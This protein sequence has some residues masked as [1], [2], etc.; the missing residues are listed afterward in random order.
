MTIKDIII[1]STFLT[2]ILYVSKA[3][4][5]TSREQPARHLEI[6]CE[7]FEA[8]SEVDWQGHHREEAGEVCKFDVD[9]VSPQ[10]LWIMS[11]FSCGSSSRRIVMC[12][13]AFDLF[14]FV[15]LK[16]KIFKKIAWI[17]SNHLHLQLFKLM[18]GKF[19]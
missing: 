12:E 17:Q 6:K 13:K 2:Y 3:C 14:K 7:N 5:T 16:Y 10:E 11:N 1:K 19:T 15:S 4:A 18:A 9:Q 8:W